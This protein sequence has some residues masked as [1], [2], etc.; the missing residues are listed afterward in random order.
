MNCIWKLVQKQEN[1]HFNSRK[2]K[3][4]IQSGVYFSDTIYRDFSEN[5]E[6][7]I[8]LLKVPRNRGQ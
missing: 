5:R 6:V 7:Q 8:R 3:S 1:K 2:C 4:Y